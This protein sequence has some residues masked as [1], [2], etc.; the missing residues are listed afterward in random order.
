MF[1]SLVFG[2][3]Y[4]Y[5]CPLAAA[6]VSFYIYSSTVADLE[7]V[8]GEWEWKWGQIPSSWGV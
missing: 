3:L 7:N 5:N 4:A 6:N 1:L 2:Y 8:L